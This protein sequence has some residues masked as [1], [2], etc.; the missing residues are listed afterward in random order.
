MGPKYWL[1]TVAVALTVL[2]FVI[3]LPNFHLI[4]QTM[5]GSAM[6]FWQKT[7][8]LAGLLGSWRTNFTFFSQLVTAISAVLIG[9]QTSLLVFS[10]RQT[11][12]LQKSFGVSFGG[13]VVSLLG[14]GCVSCGSVII[15]SIIG[16][17]AASAILGW[18]PFQGQEIGVIGISFLLLAIGLTVK[19]INQP[20][21]C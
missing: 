11:I 19:K 8:L 6:T 21:V 1:L 14:V 7:N 4:T 17:G 5:T 3:W 13:M 9:V 15:T 16:L 20:V 10:L 2:V 12:R 18:L